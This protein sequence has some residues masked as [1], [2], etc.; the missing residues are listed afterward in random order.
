MQQKK[1]KSTSLIKR[2]VIISVILILSLTGAF[3]AYL[4]FMNDKP[5]NAIKSAWFDANTLAAARTDILGYDFETDKW[6]I[7]Y[8]YKFV[9]T[10]FDIFKPIY[11][12]VGKLK[13]GEDRPNERTFIRFRI[14]YLERIGWDNWKV[15]ANK[16]GDLSGITFDE[17]TTLASKYDFSQSFPGK[18][19]YRT[20]TYN[21]P[22][23][24]RAERNRK[25]RESAV[26]E[27]RVKDSY[28]QN[29]KEGRLA[30]CLSIL[31]VFEDLLDAKRSGKETI[32]NEYG[33]ANL[34]EFNE[35]GTQVSV[36]MQ[37]KI[38]DKQD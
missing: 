14:I 15:V 2:L 13:T 16:D 6:A 37:K 24:E 27:K 21:P 26:I 30:Y 31:K 38:C 9:L 32:T 8:E 17:A 22:T 1:A 11:T 7:N 23:Q 3:I 12:Y 4:P 19:T 29:T 20:F 18:E 5:V 34:S 33:T 10:K 35:K 28:N 36:D 25:F